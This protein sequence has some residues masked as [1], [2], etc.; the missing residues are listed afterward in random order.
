MLKKFDEFIEE[1]ALPR[2]QSVKQL[3]KLKKLTSKTD[4]GRKVSMSKSNNLINDKNPIDEVESYED[5][6]KS[7]KNFNS[8]WNLKGEEPYKKGKK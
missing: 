1:G 6:M 4:I 8:N 3:K 2:E 5:F 7:N